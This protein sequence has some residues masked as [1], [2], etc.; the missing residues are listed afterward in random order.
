M[1][2]KLY[3]KACDRE[4]ALSCNNL[5]VMYDNGEGGK[6]DYIKPPNFIKKPAMEEL[7]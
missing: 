7:L 3:E 6:Q 2:A 4:N 5:G 1:A